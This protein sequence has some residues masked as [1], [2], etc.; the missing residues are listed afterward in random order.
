MTPE[1]LETLSAGTRTVMH[2]SNGGKPVHLFHWFED[3]EP[4]TAFE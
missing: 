3:S 4:R 2:S 1:F